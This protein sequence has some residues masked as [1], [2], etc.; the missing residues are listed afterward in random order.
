MLGPSR[1]P[2]FRKH[3]DPV[4]RRRGEGVSPGQAPP[5]R[6]GT[7]PPRRPSPCSAHR[8]ASISA[9]AATAAPTLEIS[10]SYPA[11]A[12]RPIRTGQGGANRRCAVTSLSPAPSSAQVLLFGRRAGKGRSAAIGGRAPR[13]GGARAWSRDG[14]R[15]PGGGGGGGGSC[16]PAGWRR[17][18]IYTSRCSGVAPH[19]LRMGLGL[20]TGASC[21]AAPKGRRD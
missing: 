18:A 12:D 3:R 2:V 6:G 4:E 17:S 8:T 20:R 19:R 5:A 15:G 21:H 1:T 7:P 9:T 11:P 14:G 16:L 10:Q 13:E